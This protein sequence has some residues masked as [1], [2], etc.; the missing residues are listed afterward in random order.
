MIQ[1]DELVEPRM[2]RVLTQYRESPKLLHVIRTFLGQA[3]DAARAV[4]DLP[5]YFDIE[6]AVGDQLTL[7]GRRMGWP[8]HH[9]VQ[10][11]QPVFGFKCD[12]VGNDRPLGG[13]CDDTVVWLA[14]AETGTAEVRISDD[15]LYRRFLKARRY[16]MTARYD[17]PGLEAAV[18]E[19]F[20]DLAM[21]LDAGFGRVV[22]APYR[23][24][25]SAERAIVQLYPRVLPLQPGVEARFHF[26]FVPVFGFGT[27]WGGFCDAWRS[28][29]PIDAPPHGSLI[30]AD[31]TDITT[32][33][34]PRDAEWMCETDVHPYGCK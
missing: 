3:E 24:L 16:Q 4:D 33:V 34:Q 1:P 32:G 31:S 26:G 30:D 10:T 8:R 25:T 9:R 7:L 11:L 27:G 17:L 21:V 18:R 2:D 13:F 12:G 23:E 6:S 5:A 29:V 14:C 15:T 19:L 22:I 28:D 20:G